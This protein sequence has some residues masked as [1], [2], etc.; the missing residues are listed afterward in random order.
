M[1]AARLR[2]GDALVIATH[3]RHKFREMA[4]L[5]APYGLALRSAAELGLSEPEETGATFEDNARLKAET[6]VAACGLPVL[7]DDSGLA[8][9]ALA[10]APGI[11][12]ARWAGKDRDFG[13]AMR[14][15]EEKLAAAGATTPKRRRAKFVAVL[16]YA[17]PGAPSETY[18]GEVAG[19]LVWPPRGA[20]GFGYDPMFVPA[21][22]TRT[23]AEMTASDKHALSHRARAAAAFAAARI[24]P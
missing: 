1:G 18:R 16:C 10:G 20:N 14:T 19:T 17:V 2:P 8:V 7:G 23:F 5:L 15:I 22:G 3:N 11:H 13:H 12:S 21:G 9:D 4:D 24:A 6:A